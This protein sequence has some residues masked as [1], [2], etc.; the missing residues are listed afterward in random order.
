M[1]SKT[2]AAARVRQSGQ[3]ENLVA[4]DMIPLDEFRKL[5][6]PLADGLSDAEIERSRDFADRL[7]DI[8]FDAWL[9]ARNS[10]PKLAESAET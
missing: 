2:G 6:G 3:G 4:E 5:L 8:I 9:R 10:P 7:A 1:S